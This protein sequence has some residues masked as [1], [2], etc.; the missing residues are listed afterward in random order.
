MSLGFNSRGNN[1]TYGRTSVP[2][3]LGSMRGAGSIIRKYNFC[4]NTPDPYYCLFDLS[5]P[6]SAP[7]PPPPPPTPP[8]SPAYT[9]YCRSCHTFETKRMYLGF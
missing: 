6:A 7:P 4:L 9:F 3:Y 2:V 8:P 5:R 1:S